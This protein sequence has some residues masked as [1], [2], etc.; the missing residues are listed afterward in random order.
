MEEI[1]EKLQ[2]VERAKGEAESLASQV[3]GELEKVQCEKQEL[4]SEKKRLE[5]ANIEAAKELTMAREAMG[6]TEDSRR[7]V[8]GLQQKLHEEVRDYQCK[9]CC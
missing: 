7:E 9:Q 5:E 4:A 1:Q 3:Q 8:E 6:H 2:I